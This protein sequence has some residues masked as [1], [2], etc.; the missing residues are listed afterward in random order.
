LQNRLQN[1]NMNLVLSIGAGEGN[2]TLDIQL[3]KLSTGFEIA[4]EFWL[5]LQPRCQFGQERAPHGGEAR[6]TAGRTSRSAL[7]PLATV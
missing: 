3:G 7:D 1:R 6:S 4:K 5:T 2:R